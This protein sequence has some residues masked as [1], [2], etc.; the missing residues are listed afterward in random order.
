MKPKHLPRLWC[1]LHGLLPLGVPGLAGGLRWAE[2][3]SRQ[4]ARSRT[5]RV[6]ASTNPTLNH[7]PLPRRADRE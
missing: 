4:S 1:A 2:V 7:R 6:G 3:A 5:S